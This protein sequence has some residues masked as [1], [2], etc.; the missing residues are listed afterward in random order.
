[1]KRNDSISVACELNISDRCRNIYTTSKSNSDKIK[2]KNNGKIICRFCSFTLKYSGRN[3]PN[4]KYP[5]DDNFFSIVDTK[6]KAYLLGWISSDGHIG[7]FGFTITI[8]GDDIACLSRLRDIICKD[9]PIITFYDK[10]YEHNNVR[11]KITSQQISKDLCKHLNI[12]PGKKSRTIDFPKLENQILIR[13]FIKG[14]F[15]GDGTLNN[16][17]TSNINIPVCGITSISKKSIKGLIDSYPN[18]Y[19]DYHKKNGRWVYWGGKNAISF[20]DWIYTNANQKLDRKYDLYLDWKNNFI[21][22]KNI[23][24]LHYLSKLTEQNVIEIVEKNRDG[25]SQNKLAKIYKVSRRTIQDILNG[26]TWK[27]ITQL[28]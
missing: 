2:N 3:N 21:P 18:N 16:R 12:G 23:G 7:K 28:K 8:H 6:E 17:L 14:Y 27:K 5:I 9:V 1:M 22:D 13:E 11:L 19:N 25:V 10:K 4:M 26:K 24:E 15:E 20:L